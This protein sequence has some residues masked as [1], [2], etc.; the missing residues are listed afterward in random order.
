MY[1][2]LRFEGSSQSIISTM[3][4]HTSHVATDCTNERR[5]A[6]LHRA[7]LDMCHCRWPWVTF[8]IVR[9]SQA[10]SNAS[11]RTAVQKLTRFQLMEG[12]ARFLCD[13]WGFCSVDQSFFLY[14]AGLWCLGSLVNKV[15]VARPLLPRTHCCRCRLWQVWFGS[16]R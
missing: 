7:A 3:A 15:R 6:L 1:L 5:L 14:L 8:T 4:S 9:L 12:V 2:Y 11:T 13:S 10:L 16:S